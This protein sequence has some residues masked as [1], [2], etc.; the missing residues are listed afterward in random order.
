MPPPVHGV[1][2]INRYLVESDLIKSKFSFD[3]L[4]LNFA[5][6]VNSIGRI[7]LRKLTLLLL[8]SIQL[9]KSLVK[10]KPD[11]VYFTVSPTGFAFYRDYFY[12]MIIKLF[13]VKIV[14]HLHGKGVD[15][16]ASNSIMLKKLYKSLFRNSS[17]ICLSNILSNDIRSVFSGIPFVVNNGIPILLNYKHK[18]LHTKDKV[19]LLFLSNLGKEKGIIRFLE[20]IKILQQERS[21]FYANII[22][23]PFDVS[24]DYV[25]DFIVKNNLSKVLKYQGAKYGEAKNVF[26]HQNTILIHPTT[27]DAFPL[28]ILEAMRSGIP[29][30]STFEGAIPEIIDVNRTGFLIKKVTS[31]EI[32]NKVKILLDSPQLRIQMGEEGKLKFNQAYTLDIFEKRICEVFTSIDGRCVE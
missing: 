19:Q 4:S 11:I 13:K 24:E 26:L 2:T 8:F 30:I 32:V 3:V 29:V 27:N 9:V 6:E 7:S 17:V 14:Y 22:G 25:L 16:R 12:A 31:T 23:S 21:D 28:V 18:I 20:A 5:T 15:K 1:S 10:F